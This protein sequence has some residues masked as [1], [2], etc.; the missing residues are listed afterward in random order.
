MC[1]ESKGFVYELTIKRMHIPTSLV[2]IFEDFGNKSQKKEYSKVKGETFLIK[3][4]RR[5]LIIVEWTKL[6][7]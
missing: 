5:L 6:C 1:V 4:V 2:E 3:I 7:Y